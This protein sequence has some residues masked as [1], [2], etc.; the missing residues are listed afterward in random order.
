MSAPSFFEGVVEGDV[1]DQE[2]VFVPASFQIGIGP[3]APGRPGPGAITSLASKSSASSKASGAV[4][5]AASH[6]AGEWPPTAQKRPDGAGR[7]RRRRSP[8]RDAADRDPARVGVA[9]ARGQRDRF[10]DDVAV[11]VAFFAVVP[12]AVVAAVGEGDHRRPPAEPRQRLEHRFVFGVGLLRSAAA[13]E[14]DEQRRRALGALRHD[15]VHAQVLVHR[16]AVDG[17]MEDTGAVGVGRRE[18]GQVEHEPGD[19]EQGQSD[20]RPADPAP[21]SGLPWRGAPR[22]GSL[23]GAHR[24][25]SLAPL[26]LPWRRC[27]GLAQADLPAAALAAALEGGP[28]RRRRRRGRRRSPTST[29]CSAPTAIRP[30][31]SPTSPRPGRDRPRCPGPARRQDEHDARRPGTQARSRSGA[32]ARSTGSSSPATT[33]AGPTTSRTRCARRWSTT[34]CRR[35]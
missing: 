5:S 18:D 7:C 32:P 4:S 20:G 1:A 13:M 21:A 28:G 34:A 12:V 17:E 19:A 22:R 31:T 14:E 23:R 30:P 33:T 26:L 27:G 2:R 16:P 6:R 9:F 25:G 35:G 11:P 10:V 15:D 3:K 29:S 24:R 8:H